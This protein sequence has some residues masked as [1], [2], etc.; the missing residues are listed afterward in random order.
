MGSVA[1]ARE[2]VL[3]RMCGRKEGGRSAV[4]IREGVKVGIVNLISQQKLQCASPFNYYFL[5][6]IQIKNKLCVS[7]TAGIKI[8]P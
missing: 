4:L 7:I 8:V 2:Q 5:S 3:T 1:S 6:W